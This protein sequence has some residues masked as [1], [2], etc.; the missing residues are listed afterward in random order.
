MK[1]RP[2]NQMVDVGFMKFFLTTSRADLSMI[3]QD[4]PFRSQK[5]QPVQRNGEDICNIADSDVCI[6]AD[7]WGTILIPVI[8]QRK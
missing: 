2:D 5:H 1:N 8:Q 3:P 6:E 7:V 4:S